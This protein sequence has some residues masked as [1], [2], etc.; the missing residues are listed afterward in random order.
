MG[1][2][3]IV[4]DIMLWLLKTLLVLMLILFKL[5]VEYMTAVFFGAHVIT[6][7][8]LYMKFK[9]EPLYREIQIPGPGSKPARKEL[10]LF[11]LPLI[12]SNL[13]SILRKRTDV[14]IIGI[15]FTTTEVGLYYAA[16]PFAAILT[17]FLFSI[18]KIIMPV[19]SEIIGSGD[20]KRAQ[21]LFK[22][23]ALL[24][25]QLTLPVFIMVFFFADDIILFVYGSAFSPAAILLKILSIGFFVNAISGSF[26]EF[27]QAFGKTRL[28][29]YLSFVGGPLNIILMAVLVPIYGLSGAALSTSLV[30]ISMVLLG[31]ILA[32]S[33]LKLNPFSR[34]YAFMLALS[35]GTFLLF[36]FYVVPLPLLWRIGIFIGYCLLYLVYLLKAN[37]HMIKLLIYPKKASTLKENI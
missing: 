36:Q 2:I 37:I 28:V 23:F 18:N 15:F 21:V 17:L 12:F 27:F 19:A 11:S 6:N 22:D 33:V 34:R 24:S 20:F 29:F 14:L 7:I 8:Y 26:G 30:L 5:P 35:A 31:V 4:N 32:Q 16:Y 25:F 9:Q 3:A 1:M 10:F 13:F